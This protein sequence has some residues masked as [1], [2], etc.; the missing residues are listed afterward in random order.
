MR[1]ELQGLQPQL[2]QTSL[3]TMELIKAIERDTEEVAV[4][5]KVVE[6][7]EAV[8]NA[9]ATDAKAIKVSNTIDNCSRIGLEISR[10]H[11]VF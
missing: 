8:A 5:K 1:E 11:A 4:V 6:A 7:D 10:V 9:A 3:E 2:E